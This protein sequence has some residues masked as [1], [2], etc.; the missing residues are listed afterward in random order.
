MAAPLIPSPSRLHWQDVRIHVGV[1]QCHPQHNP[2]AISDS[3]KAG[4]RVLDAKFTKWTEMDAMIW[5]CLLIIKVV[6]VSVFMQPT[7]ANHKCFTKLISR[8]GM[9]GESM[10]LSFIEVV[11]CASQ[12]SFQ[13]RHIVKNSKN[14]SFG[15]VKKCEHLVQ[16]VD[17][18][19]FWTDL[20]DV[21]SEHIPKLVRC[22]QKV[23]NG[24]W[25]SN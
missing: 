15:L 4:L 21:D 9:H 23:L 12:I 22:V 17:K 5:V 24:E 25:P 18:F 6:N 20:V 8:D 3:L 14:W 13:M 10:P 16:L 19:E 1:K 7:R 11:Y 2:I